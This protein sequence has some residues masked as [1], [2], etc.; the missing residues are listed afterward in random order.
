MRRNQKK[1]SQDVEAGPSTD[2]QSTQGGEPLADLPLGPISDMTSEAGSPAPHVTHTTTAD[3][4]QGPTSDTASAQCGSP[5]SQAA[6]RTTD[7]HILITLAS[8]V[9]GMSVDVSPLR[10]QKITPLSNRIVKVENRGRRQQVIMDALAAV[11]ICEAKGQVV[12]LSLQVDHENRAITLRVAGNGKVPTKVVDHLTEVWERL[13]S[14]SAEYKSGRREVDLYDWESDHG[15]SLPIP[16]VLGEDGRT[17]IVKLV[18]TFSI[19]KVTR[20]Y[21]KWWRKL[22]DLYQDYRTCYDKLTGSDIPEF[23]DRFVKMM[24]NL[25]AGV[26]FLIRLDQGGLSLARQDWR[27]FASDTSEA[28]D[29]SKEIIHAVWGQI[30]ED[31]GWRGE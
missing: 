15:E 11:A 26:G 23:D 18:Y 10:H 7:P 19:K 20:R 22:W 17:D 5:T 13:S 21:T 28:L 6:Y 14:L 4:P 29:I 2:N 16:T 8:Q 27:N 3:L 1:E 30:G 9:I 12:A 24:V 31:L 25:N